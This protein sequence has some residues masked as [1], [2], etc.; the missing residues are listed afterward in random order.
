MDGSEISASTIVISHPF[1]LLCSS[2]AG[3]RKH[4]V[5]ATFF[6]PPPLPE[7]LSSVPHTLSTTATA[8]ATATGPSSSSRQQRR[9]LKALDDKTRRALCRNNRA[10]ILPCVRSKARGQRQQK[11]KREQREQQE[12]EQREK[13]WQRD[14]RRIKVCLACG[15]SGSRLKMCSGCWKVYLC[16]A[17]YQKAAWPR[18]RADCVPRDRLT[19]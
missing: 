13:Q 15:K 10:D 16:N 5:K 19:V 3:T 17:D 14:R 2:S 18:H 6:I 9:Q 1:P 11:Q 4:A 7:F 12:R 8:T